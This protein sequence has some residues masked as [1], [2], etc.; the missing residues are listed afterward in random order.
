V[1]RGLWEV[2]FC[3]MEMAGDKPDI[4]SMSGFSIMDR[5][6]LAYV[7]RDSTYRRWPSAYNVSNAREDFPEPE[8]PVMTTSLSR[9]IVRSMFFRLW[10]RAPL[11]IMLS[12]NK[13]E[14]RK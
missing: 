6:C 9:G 4:W 11:T 5:N 2:D 14:P 12:I 7:D 3:S 8:M 13:C 1:E 10:V